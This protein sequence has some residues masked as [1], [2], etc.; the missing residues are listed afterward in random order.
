MI[1]YTTH[2][3]EQMS[4]RQVTD[5]DVEWALRRQIRQE[6]GQ[7]GSVWVH[8]HASGGRILKVCVVATDKELVKTVA[9]PSI[10]V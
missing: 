10:R 9:W 6:P 3:R 2:A 8:G 4:R 5:E 7:P 1:R